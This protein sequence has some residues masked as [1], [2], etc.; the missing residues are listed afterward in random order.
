MASRMYRRPIWVARG[1][2]IG[3]EVMDVVLA[4]LERLRAPL[5]LTFLDMGKASYE[6]GHAT[7]IGPAAHALIESTGVLLKGPME[8]PT[9][10]GYKSIN[11]TARKRWSAYANK[12]VFRSLPNVETPFSRAH[13]HVDIVMVRENIEDTYGAIEHMLTH[14]VALCRRF[15]TR[16]GSRQVHR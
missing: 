8:T 13:K 1:D 10:K 11:V 3:P 6:A 14:D 12:R 5:D 7:G 16:P 4:L 2:G 15:I 9:G